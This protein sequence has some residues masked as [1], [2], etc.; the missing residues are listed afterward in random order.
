M[1]SVPDASEPPPGFVQGSGET[2][3]VFDAS[4]KGQNHRSQTNTHT[5]G[6]THTQNAL[7]YMTGIFDPEGVLSCVLSQRNTKKRLCVLM[8][9][10]VCLTH[11]ADNQLPPADPAKMMSPGGQTHHRCM[12]RCR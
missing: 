1:L 2:V 9:M 8:S 5:H 6:R 3:Y 7:V 10:P 4:K 11:L 12:L